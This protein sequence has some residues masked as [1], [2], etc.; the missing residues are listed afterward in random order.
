[1]KRLMVWS[2]L[3]A[4]CAVGSAAGAAP[5]ARTLSAPGVS[6]RYLW[7]ADLN[8]PGKNYQELVA[9]PATAVT[10]DTPLGPA[11]GEAFELKDSAGAVVAEARVLSLPGTPGVWIFQTVLKREVAKPTGDYNTP[12]FAFPA[13]TAPR[14][15]RHVFNFRVEE[16]VTPLRYAVPTTGPVVM[17]TEGLDAVVMSP[18]DN[19]MD[20]MQAPVKGEWRCGFGGMLETIPAG[21]TASTLVVSGQ[22]INA[23]MLLWGGLIQKWYGHKTAD[24]YADIALR[25]LGYWTDN[26]AYYYYRTE[27]GMNYAETLLAIKAYGEREKIPFGYIQL[28]SWWY[29]KATIDLKSSHNRGGVSLW[30]PEPAMFPDGMEA[31]RAKLGLPLVAHNRYVADDSPY[32]KKYK[33]VMGAPGDK[34]KGAYPIDPA[35]WDEIMDNAKKYGIEVYEQDWLYTHMDMIPW[36]RSGFGN[37]ASWYDNM[38]SAAERR[39]ITM[40]LCMASPEFFLQQLKH[41]NATNARVSHD[42]KGGL[43]KAFFWMPFHKASLFAY[44]VGMWPFKDNFQS[45]TGQNPQYVLVPE[46]NPYEEC[47]ISALSGGPVGPSDRIGFTDRTLVMRTCR[48]DGVLLKPDRPATPIDAM[49]LYARNIFIGGRRPWTVAT[50]SVHPFGRTTYLATFNLWP[51]S[52][53]EPWVKLSELGLS[54]KHLVYNYRTGEISFTENK[55]NFTR[56]EPDGQA[57]NFTLAGVPGEQVTVWVW[58]PR[59]PGAVLTPTAKVVSRDNNIYT[60]TFTLP[61]SG[62]AEMR[63][64]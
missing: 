28:D 45:S 35:Y 18:L 41:G 33:C 60:Y 58:S 30:E 39:G 64:E 61:E 48:D 62:K 57:V 51:H 20:A 52:M 1:M 2:V 13:L 53:R 15:Y 27:P 17:Y 11:A 56:A 24:P 44:A 10:Q 3:I 7:P 12:A 6:Y 29:P 63:L 25:K 54:G 8:Q 9:G 55:I 47:L 31:F 40:Q 5:G 23:S 19:F 26:G 37:A 42:Y 14:G 4:V 50:E 59:A 36:M 21:V 49:F 34:R 38:A 46:G 43:P 16:F 32:C 22:G